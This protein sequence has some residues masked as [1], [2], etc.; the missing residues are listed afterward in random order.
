MITDSTGWKLVETEF[1]SAHNRAYEGL[2]TLGSGTLHIRGSLEEHLQ[3]A[4]QH[5]SYMRRPTNTT[6]E[7][8]P[9]RKAKWGTYVPG[10]YGDHPLLLLEMANLPWF[11]ELAP[12]VDGEVLDMEQAQISEYRRELSLKDAAL[13]RSLKWQTRS[14]VA[15]EVTFERFVSAAHDRLCMQRM[16]IRADRDATLTVRAGIDADVRTGGYD[17]FTQVN[18]EQHGADGLACHIRT[19][20]G[21]EAYTASK[22]LL[23]SSAGSRTV[24]HARKASIE[25]EITLRANDVVVIE[26]RS[27]VR[28]AL[29]HDF[30]HPAS[31][32]SGLAQ[33]YDEIYARHAAIWEK[34]WQESDVVIEGDPQSQLAMRVYLYHLMR[35]H[36]DDPRYAIEAKGYAG[37]AYRGSFFWDTEIY[38]LPFF[39]YT[40]PERARTLLQFRVQSLPGAQRN[41]ARY[42]Y[43]GARYPWMSDTAGNETCSGWEYA[44]HEVH[45]T[46]DIAFAIQHYARATG[47]V[48]FV[49]REAAQML[50]EMGRYW[51]DRIDWRKGQDHPSLLGVMGPDEYTPISDNNSYTNRVVNLALQMAAS[52]SDDSAERAAFERHA[53]LPIVRSATRPDLVLQCEG[54]EKLADLDFDAVW[55]DRSRGIAAQVSQERLY[56]SKV[57]K[58]ADVLLLMLLFA[59]EFSDHEVK[60]AWDYYLPLTSHDSSLSAGVHALIAL[61]MGWMDIALDYWQQSLA[62]DLDIE[63]GGAS[64]G[65]HIAA[66]GIVWQIAVMGFGGLQIA[67]Q[68]EVLKLSPALPTH[69]NVLKFPVTWRGQHFGVEVSRE[70]V[71]VTLYSGAEASVCVW[72]ETRQ[73]RQ[74]EPSV[75]VFQGADGRQNERA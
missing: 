58:Q 74:N 30:V 67:T 22:L 62:I 37:D 55:A 29:D 51:L 6:V 44:D 47:D 26:K 48:Q 36:P 32:L 1:N 10:V 64:N 72:G 70:R 35:S 43:R 11:L 2:F 3:D 19:D 66:A 33:S 14:G 7:V 23:P 4:P 8:F 69:W 39:L 9:D 42:G 61:R 24:Q 38:L 71:T 57:L 34:R 21:S 73:I 13:R 40:Q 20:Y 15:V 18:F 75:F 50:V 46:A 56:R 31:Y 59:D 45:V 63:G 41:A 53:H 60:S 54:F 16:T 5:V 17:H 68:Q 65:I 52:L 27:A 49:Q 12:A 28:T 25:A